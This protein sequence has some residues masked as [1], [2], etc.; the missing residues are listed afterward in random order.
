MRFI[1]SLNIAVRYFSTNHKYINTSIHGR[2]ALIQLHRPE[3]LN[4][5]CND[6]F[7]ELNQTLLK[8]DQD[9]QIGAMV[10]TGNEKAFAGIES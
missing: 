9:D 5:L 1:Q 7:N 3:A 4:A 8:Y 6:L 2:V 10:L